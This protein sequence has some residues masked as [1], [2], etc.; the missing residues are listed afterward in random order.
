MD[1]SA[2]EIWTALHGMI[3]GAGFLLAFSGGLIS[4]WDLRSGWLTREAAKRAAQRLIVWTWTMAVL[5]W[6]TVILGTYVVYPWYRAKPP[7]G[8]TGAALA[9]HPKY[10]LLSNPRTADWHEFG[11]EWK[12]HLAW[13][14]PILATAVAGVVTRYRAQIATDVQVRRALLVLYGLAFFA[15]A[16]AG[17]LGALINKAAPIR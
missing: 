2:R 5:V 1:L 6:V 11:M 14:A 3:F 10:L 15:A 16:W 9:A 13:L 8:A 7:V 17:L 4:L 12:E